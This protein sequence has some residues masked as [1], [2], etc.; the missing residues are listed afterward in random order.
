MKKF[1]LA[2]LLTF[3]LGATVHGVVINPG[4][5]IQSAINAS[6]AGD[7]IYVNEGFY[8]ENLVIDNKAIEIRGQGASKPRVYNL[9]LKNVPT[10]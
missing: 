4:Q 10:T 1:S 7:V 2:F 6:S 3:T 8:P 5:S 9:T